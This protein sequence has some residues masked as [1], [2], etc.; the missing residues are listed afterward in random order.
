MP[1]VRVNDV[2]DVVAGHDLIYVQG[3]QIEGTWTIVSNAFVTE[4]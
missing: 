3:R 1:T 2:V 4:P